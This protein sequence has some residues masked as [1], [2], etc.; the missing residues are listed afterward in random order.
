MASEALQFHID[1]II[2]DGLVL[3]EAS[4]FENVM[5]NDALSK[6]LVFVDIPVTREDE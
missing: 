2:K 3:P 4:D 1:G 6:F 5:T